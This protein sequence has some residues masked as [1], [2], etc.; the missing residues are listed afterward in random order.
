MMTILEKI[1]AHKKIEVAKQKE[2][3]S[4]DDLVN[5]SKYFGRKCFSAKE[6]I[7]A[8]GSS[9]IIAEF[10]RKSPSKNWI[11][12]KA[13]PEEIVLDYE[14]NGA[15][16]VSILTDEHFFGGKTS[17]IERIRDKTQIPILRKEF[18]IDEYQLYEA[19]AIG[20]DFVLLISEILSKKEVE[21]LSKKAKEIGLEVLLEMHSDVQIDKICSSIDLMGINNRNLDTFEVNLEKSIEMLTLL[22]KNACKIAESGISDPKDVLHLKKAGFDG[23]LI[24]EN[25][26][27][28][29]N[30]GTELGDF[31]KKIS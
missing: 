31:I 6:S 27:K 14:K 23:F 12:E 13:K 17:D 22:P 9:Q 29:E 26:M 4:I 18:I 16:C 30:P 11:N 5:K 2:K 8:K 10:K 28:T 3:I 20:A 21:T 15:A 25:F 19:K 1:V 7:L 24:G